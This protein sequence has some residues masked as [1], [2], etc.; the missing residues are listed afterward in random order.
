MLKAF[1]AEIKIIGINPFVSLPAPVLKHIFRQANKDKG[2]L[3]VRGRVNNHPYKQTLV[4]FR[5]E[6]RLYI[7]AKMLRNSPQRIGEV[8]RVSVEFDPE[9]RAIAMPADLAQAL[10]KHKAA[11]TVFDGLSPSRKKEI[12]RYIAH[13]KSEAARTRNILRAISFLSGKGRFVGRDKP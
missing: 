9:S 10:S 8:I 1:H 12:V 6:W 5:G 2:H 7:N 4:K 3:P 11:K 13:L